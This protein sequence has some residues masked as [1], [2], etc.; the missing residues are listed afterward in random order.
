VSTEADAPKKEAKKEVKKAAPKK[1]EL[2]VLTKAT[3]RSK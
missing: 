3:T 2:A 1:E